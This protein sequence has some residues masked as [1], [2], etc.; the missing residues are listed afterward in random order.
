MKGL[1]ECQI[2]KI[3]ERSVYEYQR[4]R[5]RCKSGRGKE[6]T[7]EGKTFRDWVSQQRCTQTAE[8]A[9]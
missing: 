5:G 7:Q 2:R 9:A 3:T 6:I 4:Q 1:I 8:Q